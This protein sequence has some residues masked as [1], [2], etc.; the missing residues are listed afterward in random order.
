[1]ADNVYKQAAKDLAKKLK[2]ERQFNIKLRKLFRSMADDVALDY[3]ATG[4]ALDADEFEPEFRALILEQYRRVGKA[5]KKT[6]REKKAI[7]DEMGKQLRDYSLKQS[8]FS[9]DAI[10][11]TNREKIDRAIKQALANLM[12]LEEADEDL[13]FVISA[14]SSERVAAEA[15][16]LLIASGVSRSELIAITETQKMAEFTKFTEIDVLQRNDVFKSGQITKTWVNMGDDRVRP[17]HV[18]AGGQTVDAN[19]PFIV[20]GSQMMIPA[21]DSMGAPLVE[22]IRCRCSAI[23][24]VIE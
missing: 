19:A 15:R 18:E 8:I 22:T 20:G 6:Q 7:D 11:K 12:L 4:E 24:E 17:T 10:T 21:D 16:R 3:A 9:A 1:M 14:P 13:G 2:L 23:Y 5:F